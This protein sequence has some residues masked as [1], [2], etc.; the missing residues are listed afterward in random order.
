MASASLIKQGLK[1]EKD[2][3]PHHEEEK[4]KQFQEKNFSIGAG[5]EVKTEDLD[6]RE[7]DIFQPFS[8][9]STSIESENLENPFFSEMIDNDFAGSFSPS[10]LSPTTSESAYFSVSPCHKINNF[11]LANNVQTPESDLND[12]PSAPTSV[13]NSPIG[14][15]DLTLDKMD[16]ESDFPFDSPEFFF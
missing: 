10:F 12:I 5:L 9:P 3:S 14:D 7:D 16:F 11:G 6:T 1:A 13:S 2:H 15:L 8:F 4:P